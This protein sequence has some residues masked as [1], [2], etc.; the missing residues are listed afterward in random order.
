MV[1]TLRESLPITGP[2]QLRASL[3]VLTMGKGNPWMRHN[4]TQGQLALN[5][6]AGRVALAATHS[7]D[8][9]E[10]VADGPAAEWIAPH[11]PALF[12][13]EDTLDGFA[14]TG[15]LKRI[16][17]RHTGLRLVRLPCVF[18]RLVQVVLQ[19]LILFRDAC[20][21]W[22]QLVQRYG[23]EVPGSGG[24]YFAPTAQ[25]IASLATYQLMECDIL[26]K[27][28]RTILMLA[29]Q[30]SALEQS[31]DSGTDGVNLDRLSSHLLAQPGVGEWTVGYL[32]GAGLGDADAVVLGDYGHPH[33]VAHFFTGKERSDDAEMLRLLEPYRPHRFRVLMLLILGAAPA[34]RYGPRRASLRERFR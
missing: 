31:W 18:D 4:D 30:A 25:T 28:A 2:Y 23:D 32:R 24:L 20:R 26:P 10:I 21:G 22:R 16:A 11:L 1:N 15:K 3:S 17:D 29:K 13:L 27:H 14:P 34:P 9:L 19:Q 5:T 12:G 33:Q 8:R 7:G 6:P